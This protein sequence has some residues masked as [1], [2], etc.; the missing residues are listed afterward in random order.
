MAHALQIPP[1]DLSDPDLKIFCRS[2]DDDGGG[3]SIV[4][5]GQFVEL[6]VNM[7][8]RDRPLTAEEQAE[9]AKVGRTLE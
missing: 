7:Y 5:L 3:I 4:E 6:G 9:A 8:G 2:L 1:S